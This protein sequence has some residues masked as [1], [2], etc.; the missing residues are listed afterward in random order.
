MAKVAV[1]IWMLKKQIKSRRIAE[2]Y[3]CNE[4][5][6]CAFLEGVSASKGLT[7]F[8]IKKGCPSKYFKNNRV[9]A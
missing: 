5:F 7:D 1:R 4:A 8:Y 6:V 3:G 2:E 9:A